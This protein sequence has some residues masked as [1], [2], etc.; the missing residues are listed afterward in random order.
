MT[1]RVGDTHV[2]GLWK[3]GLESVSYPSCSPSNNVRETA[4]STANTQGYKTKTSSKGTEQKGP[5]H[6]A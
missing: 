2:K 4:G 3:E 5:K 1:G 6:Q